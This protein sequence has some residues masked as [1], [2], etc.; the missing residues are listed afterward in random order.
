MLTSYVIGKLLAVVWLA[1]GVTLVAI[2]SWKVAT[3]DTGEEVWG[4]NVISPGIGTVCLSVSCQC[5]VCVRQ[6]KRSCA[7]TLL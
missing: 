1:V 5:V 3:V 7:G 6:K 2:G 4:I